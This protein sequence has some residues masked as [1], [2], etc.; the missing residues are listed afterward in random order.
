MAE[1]IA[2]P[3]I[4]PPGWSP[5]PGQAQGPTGLPNRTPLHSGV[6][7]GVKIFFSVVC[8]LMLL[9]GVPVLTAIMWVMT[10]FFSSGGPAAAVAVVVAAGSGFGL[11][12]SL[13]RVLRT[14]AWLEG[15]TLVARGTFTTRRC[16]LATAS[17]VVLDSVAETTS[18]PVGSTVMV[19][20]TGRR[21]PRLNAYQAGSGHPVRTQLSYAGGPLAP[22][23]LLALSGAILAGGRTDPVSLQTAAILR[24]WALPQPGYG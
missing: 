8:I 7:T 14:G 5:V 18:V 4:P 23:K 15:T 16:D 13:L 24:A 20:P 19:I 10:R 11:I 17:Q 21:I 22:P 12:A 9:V 1:N 3:D 6:S 2:G